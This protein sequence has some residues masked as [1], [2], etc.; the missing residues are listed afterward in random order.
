MKP[1]ETRLDADTIMFKPDDIINI[2]NDKND[3][4]EDSEGS[5]RASNFIVD[6]FASYKTIKDNKG[7]FALFISLTV[8]IGLTIFLAMFLWNLYRYVGR[9]TSS[10]TSSSTSGDEIKV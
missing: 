8:A 5:D 4:D 7:K 10:R 9:Q 6:L 2:R 3:E 1:A